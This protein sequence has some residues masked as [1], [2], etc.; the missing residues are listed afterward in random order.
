VDRAQAGLCV[1]DNAAIARLARPCVAGSV[2]RQWWDGLYI[3][4]LGRYLSGVS[5]LGCELEL[6]EDRRYKQQ[7]LRS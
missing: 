3:E 6:G 7:H 5:L 2:G 1:A 4:G